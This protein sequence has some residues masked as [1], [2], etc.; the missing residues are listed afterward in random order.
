MNS[1]KIAR[2]GRQGGV[3]PSEGVEAGEL[4]RLHHQRML[5]LVSR[6]VNT[7]EA[8]VEDAVGF[9]FLQLVRTHPDTDESVGGWLRVVARREAIRL[10]RRERRTVP[11]DS[12]TK[13]DQKSGEAL[14]L[15]ERLPAPV[16]TELAFEAREALRAVAALRCRRRRVLV[17]KLAGYSYKEIQETLGLTY[18]NVNRQLTR[19]RKDL[20]KAA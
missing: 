20:D 3:H 6:D 9:A 10:D 4:F 16:D 12:A 1:S 17:L 15:A 7:S 19:S 2:N 18:T 14:T 11:L 13:T 8:T 5:R